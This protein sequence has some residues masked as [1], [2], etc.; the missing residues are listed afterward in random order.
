MDG[1]LCRLHTDSHPT[2]SAVPTA[3]T[4]TMLCMRL[5]A[6]SLGHVTAWLEK[7]FLRILQA[8]PSNAPNVD[9]QIQIL[10]LKVS[11]LCLI[12]SFARV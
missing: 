12:C 10:L 4:S 11:E 3:L 6:Y 8:L 1:S 5:Y 2:S 7:E 9:P